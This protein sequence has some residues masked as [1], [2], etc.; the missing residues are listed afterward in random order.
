MSGPGPD[1]DDADNTKP[2]SPIT[3]AAATH[4][5]EHECRCSK[6]LAAGEAGAAVT[7]NHAHYE[8][9][10]MLRAD[11]RGYTPDAPAPGDYELVEHGTVMGA[12]YCMSELTAAVLLDQLPRLDD[13]HAL[14]A[15]RAKELEAGL[16][17]LPGLS[18]VP[19]PA[20]VDR[21]AIYE[22]GIQFTP[23]TFG[24]ATVDQVAA[25]LTA[26]LGTKIYPPRLPLHRSPLLR[27]HTKPRFAQRWTEA[28]ERA[29]GRPCPGA[30]HYRDHTLLMHHSVLL[31]DR[32]D[33]EDLLAALDK[34]RAHARD[35]KG[36]P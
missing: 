9:M 16:P 20:A 31:G 15:A 6:S 29:C 2:D 25:A 22:Y 26:E 3:D 18:A 33:V 36:T 1:S 5:P 12:N 17:D 13:Q 8:R 24:T 34:V 32:T 4:S 27:P 28:V 21:R 7:D 35:L 10:L 30:D 11:S 19:V 23:G 14:R